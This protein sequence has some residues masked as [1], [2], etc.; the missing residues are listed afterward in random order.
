MYLLSKII[1]RHALRDVGLGAQVQQRRL[2]LS[3]K[4]VLARLR[5]LKG[6]RIE[7]FMIGNG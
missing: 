3:R 6:M 7:L 1:V 2:F 4:H 5:L